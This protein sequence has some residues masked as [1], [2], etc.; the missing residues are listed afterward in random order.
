MSYRLLFNNTTISLGRE[1][2]YT[3]SNTGY[4]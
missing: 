4:K 3:F 1:T 2:H